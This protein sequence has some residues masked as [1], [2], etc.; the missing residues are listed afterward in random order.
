MKIFVHDGPQLVEERECSTVRLADGR[1]AAIW[2]GLAFP[3]SPA[4]TGIDVSQ[5]GFPPGECRS[6]D[7]PTVADGFALIEG[8][9]V[10]YVLTAGSLVDSEA[11]AAALARAGFHVLRSGRYF[12]DPVEGFEADWFVRIATAG[13]GPGSLRETVARALGTR[14]AATQSADSLRLRVVTA[15]LL[16][17]R[18]RAAAERAET[19]RLRQT[20]GE[21]SEIAAEAEAL[22]VAIDNERA[23]RESVEAELLSLHAAAARSP[24]PPAAMAPPQASGRPALRLRAEVETV[25][26]ALLPRIRLL[27]QS[28]DVI[29]AEVPDRRDL[30][31]TLVALDRCETAMPPQWKAVQK[32]EKW[33]EKS[34]V[35]DGRDDQLRVYARLDRTD[36]SWGVLVGFKGEQARDIAWLR[37]QPQ[38]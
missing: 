21:R 13:T 34:K 18:A 11:L 22:R 16:A 10:A 9:Q 29:V 19:D 8:A 17:T 36:R 30:Y 20:L 33:I 31:R 37:A 25:L 6:D 28:M 1:A 23:R 3:L 15:E 7:A 38:P 26:K 32:T 35:S 14:P 12:G 27:R 5:E 24:A 2:R 4:G